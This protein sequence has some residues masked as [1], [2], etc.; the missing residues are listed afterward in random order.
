MSSSQR[1]NIVIMYAD[2]LGFGD[3]GCYGASTIPTPNLDKLA[4]GGLRLT[5]AYATAATCTP[6][7]YSLLTG[8]YPWRNTRAKILAGDAPLIIERGAQTMPELMRCA[9][10]TTGIVGK[11]HL[12]IGDGSV[13]WNGSIDL[14]PLDVGFDRS[15]IMAA[16]NDRVPCVYLD[17]DRVDGLDPDDTLVTLYDADAPPMHNELPRGRDHHDQLTL[18]YSHGHDDAI[19]NGVSRI[20]RQAGGTSA[21]WNDEEMGEVFL[22]KAK[23]YV[24]EQKSAENPFFLY[25]AFHQPHVPRLPSPRFKGSTGLGARGDVIAEMDWCVGEF[26]AHLEAE[27]LLEN[28]L[29]I[30]S[31]DNGP[32]LDDGY[33][34]QAVEL[35]G[36]HKITGP[37]RGSKYS[38]FDGGTRVPTIVSWPSRIEPG[39]ESDA[40]CCQVD[41]CASFAGLCGYDLPASAGLDSLDQLQAWLGQDAIG[42]EEVLVEGNSG[43]RTL[44][45]GSWTC[46]PP[47]EGDFV[48]PVKGLELGRKPEPQLYDLSQDIGQIRDLAE[49]DAERVTS[50]QERIEAIMTAP[51]RPGAEA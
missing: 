43:S 41:F 7:R 48:C 38:L 26:M 10:Y 15:Y 14:T 49:E 21:V 22:G 9:G 40:I 46:I 37:L 17:Q 8:S 13:D 19:I 33:V 4:A 18:M 12:G 36:D 45:Q 42:R 50:M 27:G 28:T 25:Y 20:G 3:L 51:T 39:S 31:S 35:N 24:S 47:H 1:P 44:R 2:D 34:D 5:N 23:E 16:T 6:S 11:W 30:F 32:V 29:V